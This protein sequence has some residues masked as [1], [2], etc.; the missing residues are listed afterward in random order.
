[1]HALLLSTL[2]LAAPDR[3]DLHGTV[4]DA[5]GKPVEGVTVFIYTAGVRTGTSIYCPGCYP[6][7]GKQAVT[8]AAG[9]F[10]IPSLDPT[11]LF[12]V[13]VAG[14]GY[15]PAFAAKAD[16]AA[17]P[18]EVVIA[19]RDVSA[20][21]RSRVI[22][23][24]VVDHEGKLVVGATL[25]PNWFKTAKFHGV[26][27]GHF[28]PLAVTNLDGEF[29]ITAKAGIEHVT[30]KVEAPRLASRVS[31]KFVPGEANQIV[32]LDPGGF[33]TGRVVRDG[34][35]VPGVSLGLAQVDRGATTF[36][37][38]LEAGTDE[39]GVF[40]FSNVPADEYVIY[41]LMTTIPDDGAIPA[42]RIRV[43]TGG[44]TEAGTLEV[45][46]GHTLSGRVVLSDGNPIPPGTRVLLCR[47]E[48][49]DSQRIELDS[50]GR[51]TARGLPTETYAIVA[52]VPDYEYRPS[53]R[54][55]GGSVS[56]SPKFT[57][58]VDRDVNDL[59]LTLTPKSA[60]RQTVLRSRARR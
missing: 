51:F 28:D 9:R 5:A 31:Q 12:R 60:P 22:R 27:P 3:P 36:L 11:L 53:T 58:R 47:E 25:Q 10:I 45:Q 6:D 32:A 16:P 8:D 4:K 18:I 23:G 1:M 44:T 20:F 52:G 38:P 40:L 57:R 43:G 17:G 35:P 50:E 2:L 24:K 29:V 15:E 55:S 37:G 42:T 56:R 49:W 59:T 13:L 19:K 48:A 34:R 26:G 7:C 39:H 46:P 21:D 30:F 33:V 54:V 41:G 14:D